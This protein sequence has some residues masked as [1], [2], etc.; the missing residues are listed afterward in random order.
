MSH[1]EPRPALEGV[2]T[3][4]HGGHRSDLLPSKANEMGS[5][6][7]FSSN[8]N[9]FGP[10]PRIFSA[11]QAVTIAQ[12]PDPRATPLRHTL[13]ERVGVDV[14]A[15]LVGNGAVDMI[16]QLAIAY[17]RPNDRV[18]I[19]TPT[20][21]EYAAAVAMMGG[22]VIEHRLSP[23]NGFALDKDALIATICQIQPRFLFL[24]N[25]NN[26]TGVYYDYATVIS[27]IRAS[28]NTLFVLDEAFITFVAD[29][30]C[31]TDLLRY[32]NV[33]ILRSLTKDYA[34]TGLRIGYM[35]A[36][37][38][39]IAAIEKVQPPWAVN[40]L[41]QAATL[42]ALDDTDHLRHTLTQLAEATAALRTDLEALG[43]TPLP[44]AM[45]YF[46]L[47]VGSAAE[48]HAALLAQGILVRDCTS[49][50]LP[51]YIRIAARTSTDN[52][53]LIATLASC[54]EDIC[55]VT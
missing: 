5:I 14:T 40:A 32:P 18:M 6:L 20:F 11:M 37:P 50:G 43:F 4:V 27:L 54:K 31:A 16:Y 24:C 34:L 49:F 21:E 26:P 2:P 10:S 45:P 29:P 35:I 30:W 41:A 12:H 23:A 47:P 1:I 22:Q 19:I 48:W 9:P 17:V 51:D 53:Q 8:V 28:P 3:V 42:A 44:S 7:D 52:A 36:A 55:P 13:A 25:P 39:T 38:Q 15:L 33:L 46:L